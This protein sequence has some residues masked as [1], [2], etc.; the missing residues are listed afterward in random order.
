VV[1]PFTPKISD[2]F[3]VKEVPEPREEP[4]TMVKYAIFSP[5]SFNFYTFKGKAQKCRKGKTTH[6]F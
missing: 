4:K 1:K 6:V 2:A 3:K 5:S